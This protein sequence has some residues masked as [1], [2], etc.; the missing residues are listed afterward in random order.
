V[1]APEVRANEPVGMP[2]PSLP[3][4]ARNTKLRNDRICR[5]N[6]RGLR[7]QAGAPFPAALRDLCAA[8]AASAGAA[9]L[10]RLLCVIPWRHGVV[11][12]SPELQ[13]TKGFEERHDTGI[14]HAVDQ[15]VAAGH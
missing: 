6:D 10:C 2:N 13:G 4:F 14:D 3:I 5:A 15:A 8:V 7:A 11:D 12:Y 9:D 1:G